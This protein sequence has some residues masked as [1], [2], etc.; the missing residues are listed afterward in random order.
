MNRFPDERDLQILK[1]RQEAYDAIREPIT[2][3]CIIFSDGSEAR[4]THVWTD[5]NGEP[6]SIQTSNTVQNYGFYL[7]KGYMSYS[8]GLNS[9]IPWSHFSECSEKRT[10]PVW[11][12]HHDWAQAHNGVDAHLVCKVWKCDTINRTHENWKKG[13]WKVDQE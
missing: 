3:D 2:G 13:L 10:A 4:I 9:G 7:G 8:G 11:F 5:E 1:E 6:I 12:F